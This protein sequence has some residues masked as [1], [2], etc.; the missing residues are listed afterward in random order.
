MFHWKA[1]SLSEMGKILGFLFHV[2]ASDKPR[3]V[4]VDEVDEIAGLQ[5]LPS[6]QRLPIY[7]ISTEHF[8]ANATDTV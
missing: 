2:P 7:N 8:A 1:N 3:G 6:R 5:R 4:N